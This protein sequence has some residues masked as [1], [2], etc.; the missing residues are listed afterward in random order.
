MMIMINTTYA[1]D[2]VVT[3]ALYGSNTTITFNADEDYWV[4][5]FL[6][7]EWHTLALGGSAAVA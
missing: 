5:V 2:T 4:G 1:A 7:G 6:S 3:A